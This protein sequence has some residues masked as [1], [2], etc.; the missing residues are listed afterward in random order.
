MTWIMCI[1]E[2]GLDGSYKQI[3][4]G[5]SNRDKKWCG[6]NLTFTVNRKCE[7]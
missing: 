7:M 1:L 2:N 3:R 5:S 6:P 4:V